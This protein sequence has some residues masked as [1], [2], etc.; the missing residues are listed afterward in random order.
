MQESIN[1]SVL[2]MELL[3]SCTKP[4]RWCVMASCSNC[5]RSAS[6]FS[7]HFLTLIPCS[8]IV[9]ARHIWYN[10]YSIHKPDQWKHE[11]PNR[12]CLMALAYKF[13]CLLYNIDRFIKRLLHWTFDFIPSI[14]TGCS[15]FSQWCCGHGL[16]LWS[17]FLV[18]SFDTFNDILQ[19][20][21]IGNDNVASM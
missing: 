18:D 19:G 9:Y 6:I 5:Y 4:S 15:T 12:S 10:T 20:C 8:N 13:T 21:F 2:Q 1:S 14:Y 7:F 11:V 3:Q 17:K 16:W